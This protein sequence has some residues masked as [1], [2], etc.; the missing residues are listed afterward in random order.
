MPRRKH[1][2]LLLAKAAED[3]RTLDILMRDERAP[4]ASMGFSAQQATEKLLKAAIKAAG[5]DYPFTHIIDHL[6]RLLESK[7]MNVPAPLWELRRLTPF[8][9]HLRYE[10]MHEEGPTRFDPLEARE[11]IRDLRVWVEA[12]IESRDWG[13]GGAQ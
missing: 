12:F 4:V 11:R 7:G 9:A 3:E 13:E 8:A 1:V 6:L 5:L 2:E 10:P